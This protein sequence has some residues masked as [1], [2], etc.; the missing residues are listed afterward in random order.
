MLP[1]WLVSSA[2]LAT[3]PSDGTAMSPW[4]HPIVCLCFVC[5]VFRGVAN[6]KSIIENRNVG[7]ACVEA[8][9]LV[10]SALI[11]AAAADG[12]YITTIAS[13]EAVGVVVVHGC[14]V[15][16]HSCVFVILLHQL[17]SSI[18]SHNDL[19]PAGG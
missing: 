7:T 16:M 15:V 11:V 1:P 8:G 14:S 5:F 18:V 9:A 3:L 6:F 10:A 13:A 12:E 4:C 2:P 19:A 17:S